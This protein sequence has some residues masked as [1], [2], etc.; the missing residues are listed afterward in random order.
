MNLL[1]VLRNP[2]LR[3][4][5][6]NGARHKLIQLLPYIYAEAIPLMVA[7]LITS[8]SPRFSREILQFLVVMPE[9]HLE[10]SDICR[11]LF[12]RPDLGWHSVKRGVEV[13]QKV[14]NRCFLAGA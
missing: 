12:L 5:F 7:E 3:R 10:S 2:V 8:R 4:I 1:H 9:E 11:M 14:L 13:S 6:E